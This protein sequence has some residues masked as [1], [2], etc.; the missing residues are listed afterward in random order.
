MELTDQHFDMAFV[1]V[2]NCVNEDS[3]LGAVRATPGLEG[4]R[5]FINPVVKVLTRITGLPEAPRC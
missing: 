4:V 2:G 3:S 1:L 5:I